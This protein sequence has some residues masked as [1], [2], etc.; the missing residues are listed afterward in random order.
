MYK[1]FVSDIKGRLAL[2]EC[3]LKALNK[4]KEVLEAEY[5]ALLDLDTLYK[6][7]GDYDTIDVERRVT[8]NLI[9]KNEINYNN[10]KVKGVSKYDEIFQTIYELNNYTPMTVVELTKAVNELTG[11]SIVSGT[12]SNT[13]KSMLDDGRM[14]RISNSIGRT[15]YIYGKIHI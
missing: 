10:R 15:K 12:I 5:A 14:I 2:V 11:A 4:E 13:I 7:R 8:T 3:R 6:K 1:K 9:E